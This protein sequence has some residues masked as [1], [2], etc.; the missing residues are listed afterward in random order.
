[1]SDHAYQE[2]SRLYRIRTRKSLRGQ[3]LKIFDNSI[4]WLVVTIVG[5]LTAISA[6]LIV[7]AEQWLFDLKEGR[8]TSGWWH[9]RRFCSDWR[10][11]PEIIG[12]QDPSQRFGNGS[13]VIEYIVYTVVAVCLMTTHFTLQRSNRIILSSSSLRHLPYS[14]YI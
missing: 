11:W 5:F 6:F 12:G 2:S 7:R 14:Q 9:A 8:C 4:D 1:M 3:L 13:W 10:E